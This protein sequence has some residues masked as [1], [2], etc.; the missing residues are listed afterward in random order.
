VGSWAYDQGLFQQIND[1]SMKNRG[2]LRSIWSR[3][4]VKESSEKPVGHN[5]MIECEIFEKARTTNMEGNEGEIREKHELTTHGRRLV[6]R[7]SK[8]QSSRRLARVIRGHLVNSTTIQVT[9]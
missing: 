5:P 6:R 8:D 4:K 2:K 3:E 7:K 1:N 9:K